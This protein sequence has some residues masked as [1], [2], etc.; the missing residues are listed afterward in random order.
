VP[1]F[2]GLPVVAAIG[3]GM[4]YYLANRSLYFPMRYPEGDWEVQRQLGA[5]DVWL[6]AAD[7]TRLN[8]WWF[9]RPDSRIVTLFLH[10][11]AGNIT[12]RSTHARE[13]VNAGSAL[14]LLDYRGYGRS[15]G[16]PSEAGLY[17]DASAAYQYL[18]EAGYGAENIVVHGE[19]LGTAVA[20]DLAA[21]RPCGGVVLEA[22]FSSAKDVAARV[23]PV[24]GPMV[25]W[26]FDSAAKIG[27]LR[28]PL[29]VMHG[30]HDEVIPYGLGR[31]L[32]E[33]A[34]GPKSFWTVS[35]AGHND[36]VETGGGEY[37]RRLREFYGQLRARPR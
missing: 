31:A 23:L 13:I 12:H 8:A 27:S 20:V 17:A 1:W 35:G 30:D 6:R 24:L 10:G 9:P 37:G 29:L 14:L 11:N 33:A 36:I 21:R 3:V 2:V 7:G 34:H 5:V 4:L 22:P 32:F 19:S 18:V 15:E 28:E 16:R 26:S 25:I